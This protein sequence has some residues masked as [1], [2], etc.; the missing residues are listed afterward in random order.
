MKY[1]YTTNER[2]RDNEQEKIA[3]DFLLW[4]KAQP[5]EEE[6]LDPDFWNFYTMRAVGLGL[7]RKYLTLLFSGRYS[8]NPRY[9][10]YGDALGACM[11]ALD[12]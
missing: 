10:S 6:P 12:I 1:T 7:I 8:W 5:E 11:M 3:D 4:L 9:C 2:N